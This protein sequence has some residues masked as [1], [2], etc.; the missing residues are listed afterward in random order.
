[1]TVREETG[2]GVPGWATGVVCGNTDHIDLPSW[3]SERG[4]GCDE[5]NRH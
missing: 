5:K 4:R 1:M 3:K 2:V